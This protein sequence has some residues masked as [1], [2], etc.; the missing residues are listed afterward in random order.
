MDIEFEFVRGDVI[1]DPCRPAKWVVMDCYDN[2]YQLAFILKG[3]KVDSWT[4]LSAVVCEKTFIKIGDWDFGRDLE[5][6]D[7]T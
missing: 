1:A 5:V 7:G 4:P 3:K 2:W 6:D